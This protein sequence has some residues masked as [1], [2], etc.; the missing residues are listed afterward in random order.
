MSPIRIG[1]WSAVADPAAASAASTETTV[2]RMAVFID[3][4]PPCCGGEP[5]AS[6][7]EQHSWLTPCPM[8]RLNV[9]RKKVPVSLPRRLYQLCS[10]RTPHGGNLALLFDNI[11][12]RPTSDPRSAPTTVAM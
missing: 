6:A 5:H 10:D 3:L 8:R 12:A 2:P 1:F 7:A 4:L 11:L 9:A